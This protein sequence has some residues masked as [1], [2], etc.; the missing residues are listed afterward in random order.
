MIDE[1]G[2]L[3]D[4]LERAAQFIGAEDYNVIT[5]PQ[6]K[7]VFEELLEDLQ[8]TNE[9]QLD[10]SATLPNQVTQPLQDALMIQQMLSDDPR[11][12]MLPMII[13]VQ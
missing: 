9:A 6:S 11:I 3:N 5:I 2:G 10:L 8:S 12:S 1:L 4:A 7:S 13:D